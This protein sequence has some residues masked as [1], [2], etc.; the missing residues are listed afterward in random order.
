[1]VEYNITVAV[2]EWPNDDVPVLPEYH[3]NLEED[4]R[5]FEHILRKVLSSVEALGLYHV[6]GPKFYRFALRVPCLAKFGNDCTFEL[7]WAT[8]AGDLVQVLKMVRY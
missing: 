1:M 2:V 6:I 7:E 5:V 8:T 3:V 4:D